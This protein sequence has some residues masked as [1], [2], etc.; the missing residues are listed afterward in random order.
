MHT[1]GI[2][3]RVFPGVF[4]FQSRAEG[5]A[6]KP[7]FDGKAEIKRIKRTRRGIA[8]E[9]QADSAFLLVRDSKLPVH[10]KSVQ[11]KRIGFRP[12]SH[13][14][15]IGPADDR[16]KNRRCL[17]PERRVR[18]PDQRMSG[19]LPGKSGPVFIWNGS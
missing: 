16:K 3:H 14:T 7:M 17:R 15:A 19:D 5:I 13:L 9:A 12:Y 10:R 1:T 11:S 6:G 8:H 4:N 18:L 2:G